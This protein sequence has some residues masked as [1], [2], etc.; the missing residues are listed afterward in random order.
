MERLRR[1]PY[2]SKSDTSRYNPVGLV[3]ISIIEIQIQ[4]MCQSV[5]DQESVWRFYERMGLA[6]PLVKGRGPP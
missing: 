4:S 6:V 5:V 3:K 1:I 2:R